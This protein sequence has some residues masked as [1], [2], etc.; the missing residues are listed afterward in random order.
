MDSRSISVL[1]PPPEAI[2]ENSRRRSF[3]WSR[4]RAQAK[5]SPAV[6]A[7]PAPVLPAAG[8]RLGGIRLPAGS[9]PDG[10]WILAGRGLG[11]ICRASAWGL[12][13]GWLIGCGLARALIFLG[14]LICGWGLR[15]R[16]GGIRLPAG[17]WL[18]GGC[19]LAGLWLDGGRIFGAWRL[20]GVR[21]LAGRG[22]D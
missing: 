1:S 7:R 22:L 19:I 3:C 21:I 2:L 12:R 5:R 8:L 16:L 15:L 17:T 6:K 18:D 20:D 11:G 14:F 13:G 9:W 10:G 4:C